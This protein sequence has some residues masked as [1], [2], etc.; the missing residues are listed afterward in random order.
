[1]RSRQAEVTLAPGPHQPRGLSVAQLASNALSPPQTPKTTSLSVEVP[2]SPLSCGV[3]AGLAAADTARSRAEN[4]EV[5]NTEVQSA[6][7]G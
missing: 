7:T 6:R 3:P 2:S 4:Q 1:M 5:S